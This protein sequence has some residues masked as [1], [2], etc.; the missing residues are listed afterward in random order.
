MF[1]NDLGSNVGNGA[2][3]VTMTIPLTQWWETGHK[4]KQYNLSLDEAK[5][6][7]Q[8]VQRKLQL[9]NRQAYDQMTEAALMVGEYEKSLTNATENYR[10]INANYQAGLATITDL[11][12]AQTTQLKALNELT[13]ARIQLLVTTRRYYDLINTK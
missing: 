10:L 4:I 11:L 7:Q 1:R 2:L 3:F 13:D 5:L 9:R 12:T 6:D 8:D